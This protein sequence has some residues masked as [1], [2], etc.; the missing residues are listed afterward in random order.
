MEEYDTSLR[1]DPATLRQDRVS[2]TIGHWRFTGTREQFESFLVRLK[3]PLGRGN[4]LPLDEYGWIFNRLSRRNG[5]ISLKVREGFNQVAGEIPL[6]SG[7]MF[8]LGLE[9]NS[10]PLQNSVYQFHLKLGINPTRFVNCQQIPEN[11]SDPHENWNWEPNLRRQYY[12]FHLN[13]RNQRV[14]RFALDGNDNV[15][16]GYWDLWASQDWE[17]LL[18]TYLN[19]IE[20]AILANFQ[21][22]TRRGGSVQ[23]ATSRVGNRILNSNHVFYTLNE[24]EVYKDLL[25]DRDYTALDLVHELRPVVNQFRSGRLSEYESSRL[26]FDVGDRVPVFTIPVSTGITLRIYAKQLRV[27]R[28]EVVFSLSKRPRLLHD[29]NSRIRTTQD[30]N[31]LLGWFRRLNGE[32]A[33]VINEVFEFIESRMENTPHICAYRFPLLIYDVVGNF[34]VANQILGLLIRDGSITLRRRNDPLRQY[35]RQLT[36]RGLIELN[37]DNRNS[38]RTYRVADEYRDVVNRLL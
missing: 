26:D 32:A 5:R 33:S 20:N 11:Y 24:C 37:G 36:D 2:L 23:V 34:D 19:E 31:A 22:A 4:R 30:R 27:I 10:D 3:S 15:L 8:C 7:S 12:F 35:I 18:S 28:F 29:D 1:I 17:F 13:G 14:K 6:F 25:V 9:Y 21:N 16:G 38:N